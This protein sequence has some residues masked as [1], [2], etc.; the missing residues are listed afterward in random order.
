MT[1]ELYIYNIYYV[2]QWKFEWKIESKID[3]KMSQILTK[4]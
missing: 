4:E 1:E 3:K 2:S